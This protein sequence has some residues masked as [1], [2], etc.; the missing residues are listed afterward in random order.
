MKFLRYGPIG[1]EKPGCLDQ[2]GNIRD[3]GHLIADFTPETI[4]CD[5]LAALA[6]RD[7]AD[8][9]I[10][11]PGTRI[12][13]CVGAAR[14]FYAVGLNYARHARETNNPEPKEPVLFSKSTSSICGP[15]DPII[16]PRG[17]VKTDWE[18]ELGIIIGRPCSYVT[19]DEALDYVAGF[20]TINDVSERAY[21]IE[22]GGQWIKG[23]SAPNFGPMGPWLVTTDE[24]GDPQNLTLTLS[25]NGETVQNS[26]TADMIFPVAEII[27]Y[28]SGF[29]RLMP[30]DVIATG[31]P[32]GVGMG[33]SPQRFLKAGDIVEL[34]VE[35][36]GSQ[37]QTVIS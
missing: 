26:S 3:L 20:C 18:V 36:L 33:L 16:L 11:D 29:M 2:D 28:M 7:L 10:I 9:P 30:G 35:G 37:R 6:D 32:E 12:G 34:S 24:V 23:K 22:R 25:V 13:A 31:T 17:S 27:S 21:Q 8:L 19:K 1:A 5:Q 15:N 4:T 14:N